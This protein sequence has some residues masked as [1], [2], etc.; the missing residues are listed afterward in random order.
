MEVNLKSIRE[1]L[2]KGDYQKISERAGCTSTHVYK[3]LNGIKK[4]VTIISIAQDVALENLEELKEI[5]L[6]QKKIQAS[7]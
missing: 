2:K 1:N 7:A 5:E 6:K 4:N 3:V